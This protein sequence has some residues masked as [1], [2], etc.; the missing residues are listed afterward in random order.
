M[1]EFLSTVR[2]RAVFLGTPTLIYLLMA[3]YTLVANEME[4]TRP[5]WY[6]FVYLIFGLIVIINAAILLITDL[7]RSNNAFNKKLNI[8]P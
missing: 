3:I 6:T 4:Y 5:T 7:I 1:I 8:K 2:N